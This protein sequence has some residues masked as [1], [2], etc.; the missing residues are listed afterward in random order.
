MIRFLAVFFFCISSLLAVETD[1]NSDLKTRQGKIQV[2]YNAF[3]NNFNQKLND[4]RDAKGFFQIYYG[5]TNNLLFGVSYLPGENAEREYRFLPQI[6]SFRVLKSEMGMKNETGML[7]LNYFFFYNFY[8]SLGLG[9]E[10]GYTIKQSNDFS[11]TSSRR[12]LVHPVITKLNF[13][14]RAVANVSLG[15][16]H[17]FFEHFLLGVECE[18]TIRGAQE[19]K[20]DILFDPASFHHN[21][22]QIVSLYYPM[23]VF[24][25]RGYPSN[26]VSKFATLSVHAGIQF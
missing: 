23:D 6:D 7:K 26:G 8:L 13:G 22:N 2:L 3:E 9:I 12:L 15:Y 24:F 4:N 20:R 25:G 5:F 19:A 14:D 10:R 11:F 16:R 1:S 21:A 18:Y 17:T